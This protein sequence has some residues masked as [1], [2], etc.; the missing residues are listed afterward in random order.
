VEYNT[1][2]NAVTYHSLSTTLSG[3]EPRISFDSCTQLLFVTQY[4][5]TQFYSYNPTT[6]V[7]TQ[8]ASLPNGLAIQDGFCG[9]RSGHLFTVTVSAQAYQYTIATNTWTAMPTGGPIG[10]YNSACGVGADGYLYMTDPD[11]SS[12][13]YRI[14]LQ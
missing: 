11:E 14:Q 9:D 3:G 8:L 7:Q 4:E 6:G 5:S 1:S 10:E 13:M 12:S 2:T